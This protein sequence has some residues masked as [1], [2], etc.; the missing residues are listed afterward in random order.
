MS[1]HQEIGKIGMARC[2]FTKADTLGQA[3]IVAV[4]TSEHLLKYVE[5]RPSILDLNPFF[6]HQRYGFPEHLP[7]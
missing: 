5:P 4:P 1:R 2:Y 3:K 6:G 7:L